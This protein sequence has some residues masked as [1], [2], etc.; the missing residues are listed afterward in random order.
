MNKILFVNACA[1]PCSRTYL[2][3]QRAI[4]H[5]N[6][7]VEELNLYETGLLPLDWPQLQKRDEFVSKNDF[8]APMFRYARQFV[9]ADEI[10]I[11]TPYWDLAF[12][13]ILRIYFEHITIAGLTFSYSADG[14]PKGACKA[15]RLIYVTTAGGPIADNNFGYEYVKALSVIFYGIPDAICFKAENLDIDG[16]DVDGILEHAKNEIDEYLKNER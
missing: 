5:L 9:D 2:L 11:A 8:S 15:K 16:A 1:R 3:A 10:I 14:I 7:K 12:P 13:S 4:S 6:G